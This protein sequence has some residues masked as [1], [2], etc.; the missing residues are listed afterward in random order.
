[1]KILIVEDSPEIVTTLQLCFKIRWP[2]T[3][4]YLPIW[5][6]EDRIG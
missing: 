5:E 3:I 6:P 1:M 4:W 2:E